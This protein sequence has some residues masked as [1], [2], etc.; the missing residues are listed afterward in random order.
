MCISSIPK[1]PKSSQAI[2]ETT[3]P[4]KPPLMTLFVVEYLCIGRC[5]D[6]LNG[7]RNASGHWT[8]INLG[9]CMI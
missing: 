1:E 4:M 8:Q 7:S 3:G 2:A 5:N 6:L 9:K